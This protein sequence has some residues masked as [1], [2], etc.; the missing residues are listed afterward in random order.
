M[1]SLKNDFRK[2]SVFHGGVVGGGGLNRSLGPPLRMAPPSG[3]VLFFLKKI[4]AE[5][6]IFQTF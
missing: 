3:S 2:F 6:R 1:K 5:I 4:K